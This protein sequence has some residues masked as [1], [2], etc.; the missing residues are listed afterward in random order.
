MKKKLLSLFLALTLTLSLAACGGNNVAA[1]PDAS[2]GGSAS[3]AVSGSEDGASSAPEEDGTEIPEE[4]VPLEDEASEP[5]TKPASPDQTPSKP[6]GGG[7]SAG[8]GKPAGG[9]ASNSAGKPPAPSGGGDTS[10]ETPAAVD[11]SKFYTD[12]AAALTDAPGLMEVS[13]DLIEGLYSGLTALKPKQQVAYMAM[14][15]AVACEVVA[16]EMNSAEDAKAAK[17]IL[18]AR[19]TQQG[20]EQGAFYPD[21]V[22]QWQNHSRLLVNGKYV[23]MAVGTGSETFAANF[24]ALTQ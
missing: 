12:T 19:I 22:D 4:D 23:L 14:I 13:A 5:D 21:A 15:S 9:D 11:L 3:S 16:L 1:A 10:G 6:A 2:S 7:S 24:N 18:Q 17:A 20:E 8:G